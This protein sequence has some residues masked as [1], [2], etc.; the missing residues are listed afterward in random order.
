M[1]EWSKIMPVLSKKMHRRLHRL[2]HQYAG[3]ALGKEVQNG[4]RSTVL[5]QFFYQQVDE[6]TATVYT[7]TDRDGLST[8]FLLKI[9]NK[10]AVRYYTYEDVLVALR[11]IADNMLVNTYIN[12]NGTFTLYSKKNITLREKYGYVRCTAVAA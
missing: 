6:L 11:T 3:D 9:V 8:I 1:H 12:S 7:L 2:V 4:T 10:P 5:C